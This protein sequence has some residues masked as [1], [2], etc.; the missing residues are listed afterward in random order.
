M[1]S[2]VHLGNVSTKGENLY[3]KTHSLYDCLSV[4]IIICETQWAT[5]QQQQPEVV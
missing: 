4:L 5:A 3:S 1:S 2:I